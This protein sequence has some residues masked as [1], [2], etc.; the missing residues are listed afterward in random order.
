MKETQASKVINY[1]KK[2]GSITSLDAIR[3]I[4]CTRLAAQIFN[5]KQKGYKIKSEMKTVNTR[6]GKTRVAVYSLES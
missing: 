1:L 3:E 4:G 2:H 6:N 5:L